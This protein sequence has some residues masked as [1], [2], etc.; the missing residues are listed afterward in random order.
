METLPR[1]GLRREDMLKRVAR[2]KDLK[3]Y[4]GGLPDSDYDSAVRT[5]YNVIGFHHR[6]AKAA[7]SRRLSAKT[8][9]AWRQSRSRKASISAIAA[10]SP[11][12]VR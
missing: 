4:N 12:R 7:P 1:F 8:P 9:H 5:L 3:G 11:A 10:P 6:R 2:F